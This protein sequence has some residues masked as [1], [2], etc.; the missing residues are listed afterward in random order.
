MASTPQ[1]SGFRASVMPTFQ[2]AD[3][4]LFNSYGAL[5]TG[6]QSGV[7]M[8]SRLQEVRLKR[9]QQA[10]LAE[11]AAYEQTQ[12]AG[13]EES[14]RLQNA[15]AKKALETVVYDGPI[16]YEP[17][18]QAMF[19]E[20]GIAMLNPN[21]TPRLENIAGS[22]VKVE[23]G[24]NPVTG[25]ME[26]RR[27]AE[28]PFE[29][30]KRA[31]EYDLKERAQVNN[32]RDYELRLAT[33]ELARQKGLIEDIPGTNTYWDWTSGERVQ[34]QYG[35]GFVRR[36]NPIQAL[37]DAVVNRDNPAGAGLPNPQTATQSIAVNPLDQPAALNPD[38]RF[39]NIF[40]QAQP[41]L[42]QPPPGKTAAEIAAAAK[43]V[44]DAAKVVAPI[45]ATMAQYNQLPSGTV[46]QKPGEAFTRKK[47]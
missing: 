2:G 31:I 32:E 35:P 42:V 30:E 8:A 19:D 23:S 43:V 29:A 26:Y 39:T 5:A 28:N 12:R 44:A 9:E 10:R 4:R 36:E 21:G 16:T 33:Y 25:V 24:R 7:D 46:Y 3:P 45:I 18:T 37:V 27:T 20:D 22:N 34:K 38:S 17:Q 15:A 47:P 40:N 13:L 11:Q 14:R 6:L 1:T 41:A